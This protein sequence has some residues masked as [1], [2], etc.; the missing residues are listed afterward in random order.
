MA[1]RRIGEMVSIDS[2]SIRKLMSEA[3]LS[4]RQI[5]KI[6]GAPTGSFSKWLS[7]KR[8]PRNVLD[9]IFDLSVDILAD[10]KRSFEVFGGFES[11]C[12]VFMVDIPMK[13]VH[14]YG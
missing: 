13:E 6:F 11:E 14:F 1:N 10:K 8:I 2:D 3:E 12:K 9:K 5:E 4:G 7:R